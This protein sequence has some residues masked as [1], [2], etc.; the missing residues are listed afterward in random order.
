MSQGAQEPSPAKWLFGIC[1]MISGIVL[2][3]HG[4]FASENW[5]TTLVKRHVPL[6]DIVAGGLML[7]IGCKLS[8][9]F[10]R[11]RRQFYDTLFEF[12]SARR[13]AEQI[14]DEAAFVNACDRLSQ[15]EMDQGDFKSAEIHCNEILATK[16]SNLPENRHMVVGIYLRLARIK[17]EMSQGSEVETW[18]VKM[19]EGSTALPELEQLQLEIETG[20]IFSIL[21]RLDD[22]QRVLSSC[23]ETAARL[24]AKREV[25][26]I[27]HELGMLS[28]ERGDFKE[29]E[30]HFLRALNSKHGNEEEVNSTYSELGHC[31]SLQGRFLEAGQAFITS[32]EIAKREEAVYSMDRA[33]QNFNVNWK[34]APVADRTVLEELWRNAG[35]GRLPASS[36]RK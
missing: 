25:G 35:L 14:G 31:L 20:I 6:L 24:D 27:L 12:H 29:A 15:L 2:A 10:A 17:A 18:L 23:L 21:R 1:V 22:A 11:E 36:R 30:D 33:Y 3:V 4:A 16:L 7:Y 34:R 5:T 28:R 9:G 19:R 32:Y 8:Q 26:A 13:A